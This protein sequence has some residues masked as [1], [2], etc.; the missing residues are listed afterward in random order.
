[1]LCHTAF[2]SAA[3]WPPGGLNAPTLFLLLHHSV[4]HNLP[5]E[6]EWAHK[7]HRDYQWEKQNHTDEEST[8][9]TGKFLTF[10]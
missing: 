4:P 10:T 9:V 8:N 7:G 6:H 3:V 2:D 5:G 1:M